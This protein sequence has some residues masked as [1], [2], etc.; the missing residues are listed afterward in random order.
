MRDSSACERRIMLG[1]IRKNNFGTEMKIIAVR[2]K[3][4][5]DV[6]FLDNHHFI[7]EHSI[8]QL[9]KNGCIKNPYDPCLSGMGYIG[10]GKYTTGTSRK[11]TDE[12]H[13]WRN[14]LDRCYAKKLSEKYPAYYNIAECCDEWKNFQIFAEWFNENKYDIGSERLHLDKDIKY[15]GNKIYSPYHCILVPQSI[16]EQFKENNGQKRKIDVDLPYTVRRSEN[17]RYEVSHRGKHLGTYDTIEECVHVY[18]ES[19]KNYISELINR[20]NSMP[21]EIKRIIISAMEKL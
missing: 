20:Y 12:Y 5:I 1:E 8:Y 14:M 15:K 7:K 16:N 3:S 10:V 11:H 2:N 4:D 13:C 17:G 19:K 6:E 21:V 9:F 18:L